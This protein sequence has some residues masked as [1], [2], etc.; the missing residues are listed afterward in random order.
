[1]Q[2]HLHSTRLTMYHF[3]LLNS[4]SSRHIPVAV[5]VL[6]QPLDDLDETAAE[7]FHRETGFM[8][9]LRHPHVLTFY[10]SGI[11]SESMAFLVTELMTRGSLADLLRDHT[12]AL[13][14]VPTRLQFA[15]DIAAGMEYLHGA[16]M[17]HRDLKVGVTRIIARLRP[18]SDCSPIA[19][20]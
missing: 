18:L 9:S 5:K 15:S 14:W 6:K 4:S 7:A 2:A 8:Q 3:A 11:N 19:K 1:M 10:G 16:G 20:C 13:P 17:I 12:M